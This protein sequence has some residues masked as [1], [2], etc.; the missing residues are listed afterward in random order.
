TQPEHD[1]LELQRRSLYRLLVGRMLNHRHGRLVE[2]PATVINTA[3]YYETTLL[4]RFRIAGVRAKVEAEQWQQGLAETDRVIRQALTYGFTPSEMDRV[5]RQLLAE[6]DQAVQTSQTRDSVTLAT[7][8]LSHLQ[9]DRVMMSPEQERD[10]YTPMLE[11][12]TA[13]ELA[14][15]FQDEWGRG[16]VLVKVIGATELPLADAP[17]QILAAYRTL[18]EAAVA[19]PEAPE[20]LAFPYLPVPDV[21]PSPSEQETFGDIG[22]VRYR[23]GDELVVTVKRTDFQKETVVVSVQFGQGKKGLPRPGLDLLAAAV[24]NNSGSGRY[25]ATELQQILAGSSVQFRFQIGE[26]AFSWEGQAL[27]SDLEKLLQM[28]QT[29]LVDQGFRQDAYERAMENFALMYRQLP[30][31]VEGAVRLFLE[32]FFAGGV[33]GFGLPDWDVFSQLQLADVVGWL[34]PS[35]HHA[36]LEI[37]VVGDIDP[38][39]VRD[40]VARYFIGRPVLEMDRLPPTKPRFPAGETLQESV[41]TSIDKAVVRTAWLTEDFWDISRSRRLHVLAAVFEDRLR[42]EVRE[43][44]GASYSPGVY[45][46]T[47]RSYEGYGM[48]VAEVVAESGRVETVGEAIEAVAA[49]L[50]NAVIDDAELERA[51]NPLATSLKQSVRSNRYWLHSVLALSSRHPEQLRWPLTMVD[52]FAAVTGEEVRTLADRYLVP[53]RRAVGIV[54]PAAPVHETSE[55]VLEE[56]LN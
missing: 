48:V 42:R 55:T 19:P 32:P 21:G 15:L 53:Q 47:S 44:L 51:K 49:S 3:G 37:S 9:V 56:A 8:V 6:L 30:K 35:F 17:Q 23:F 46:Y 34:E 16:T 18:Q 12:V 27:Q 2:D 38:E 20:A 25:R 26:E 22:A 24:V 41:A 4:D 52:D 7:T 50:R 28:I 13:E 54:K 33:P 10:L 36:P 14:T 45:S 5:K 1:S 39:Q 29:V 40:L 31:S 11:A 43:R